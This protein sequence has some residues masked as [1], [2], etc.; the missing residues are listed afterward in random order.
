MK[1]IFQRKKVKIK[2][3][4]F[5]NGDYSAMA[6]DGKYGVC[7]CFG[8]TSEKAKE[9]ALFKLNQCYENENLSKD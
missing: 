9:M 6:S 2:V 3:F 5:G 7:N 8:T 1:E 4:D